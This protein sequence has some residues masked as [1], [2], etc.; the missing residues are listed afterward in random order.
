MF[1][2]LFPKVTGGF[3]QANRCY[4]IRTVQGC[5]KFHQAFICYGP[6]D[7]QRLLLDYGFVAPG[8]PHAVVYV[9]LGEP[10]HESSYQK[11]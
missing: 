5:R 7:N 8:N 9:D 11:Y 2:L 6:H 10:V 1:V 4:E 3:N